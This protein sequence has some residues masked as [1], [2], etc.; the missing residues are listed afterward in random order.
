M[1]PEVERT[2]SEWYA[3]F[4]DVVHFIAHFPDNDV[5][6]GGILSDDIDVIS[7]VSVEGEEGVVVLSE[8]FVVSG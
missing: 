7:V 5:H 8:F 4:F 3:D 6:T 1:Y 2:V